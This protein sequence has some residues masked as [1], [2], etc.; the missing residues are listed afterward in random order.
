M[1][2][3]SAVLGEIWKV[4]LDISPAAQ[5]CLCLVCGGYEMGFTSDTRRHEM[6]FT[7]DTRD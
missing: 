2:G 4:L 6:G 1:A 7:L 5:T 3:G